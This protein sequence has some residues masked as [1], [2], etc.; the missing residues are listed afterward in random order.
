MADNTVSTLNNLIETLKDGSNGFR[1]AAEDVKDA[2]VKSTFTQFASQRAQMASELQ[3]HVQKLGGT[4]ETTGSTAAAMHRGWINL[5]QALG[6]G[7][8]GILNE[9]ER[10][11]DV[12]VKSF[13]KAASDRSRQRG[14][15]PVWRSEAGARPRARSARFLEIAGLIQR[16]PFSG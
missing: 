7:E 12:A 10:G 14:S 2:S 5:K 6:A 15:P 13:E 8:K 16:D 4:P 1:T 3:Q 11:E 9:A